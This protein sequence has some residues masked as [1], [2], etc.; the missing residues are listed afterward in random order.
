MSFA[1]TRSGAATPPPAPWPSTR[2]ARGAATS[3]TW[4]CAGPCSVS[5]MIGLTTRWC[6]AG[7]TGR[8]AAVSDDRRPR[9]LVG[10]DLAARKG[11]QIVVAC[12]VLDDVVALEQA[13]DVSR[14]LVRDPRAKFVRVLPDLVR[15]VDQG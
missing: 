12:V 10:V 1:A 11:R 14:L 2:A 7:P 6:Q 9:L 8:R 5:R 15:L 4:A 3:W 13:A